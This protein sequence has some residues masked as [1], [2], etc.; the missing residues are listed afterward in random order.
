[1]V[2]FFPDFDECKDT[3]CLHGAISTEDINAY[4]SICTPGQVGDYCETDIYSRAYAAF[5]MR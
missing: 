2:F 4:H 1:M 5:V 3:Q